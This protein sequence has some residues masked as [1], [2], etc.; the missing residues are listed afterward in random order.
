MTPDLEALRELSEKADA[1]GI[2]E[3]DHFIVAAVNYVRA[4]LATEPQPSA[5]ALDMAL[6]AISR[7]HGSLHLGDEDGVDNA[8][9]DARTALLAASQPTDRSAEG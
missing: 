5:P 6:K 7:A 9:E 2:A 4:L 1:G 3:L 8:L